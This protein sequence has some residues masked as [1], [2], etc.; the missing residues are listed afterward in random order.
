MKGRQQAAER[1][2][3]LALFLAWQTARLSHFSG[4]RLPPLPGELKKL[5]PAEPPRKQSGDEMIQAMRAIRA[6]MGG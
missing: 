2:I 1:D 4:N 5:R 6:T 3:E